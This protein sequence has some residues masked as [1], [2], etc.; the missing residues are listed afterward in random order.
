MCAFGHHGRP[1][2]RLRAVAALATGMMVTGDREGEVQLWSATRLLQRT[3]AHNGAIRALAVA[4]DGMRFASG[5]ED[6]A[7][8]LWDPHGVRTRRI[9][10]ATRLAVLLDPL[11]R[12]QSAAGTALPSVAS[13]AWLTLTADRGVGP[14]V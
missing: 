6:G 4:P 3:Q 2:G 5:G 14:C 8:L 1:A 12:A 7:V 9:D 11:G 10:L 13:L